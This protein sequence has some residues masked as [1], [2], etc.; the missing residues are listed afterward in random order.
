MRTQIVSLAIVLA[1]QGSF[2]CE[3]ALTDG[4]VD[5]AARLLIAAL[6]KRILSEAD[7]KELQADPK[8]LDSKMSPTASSVPFIVSLRRVIERMSD[9]DVDLLKKKISDHLQLL[10]KDHLAV[11]KAQRGTKRL[12]ISHPMLDFMDEEITLSRFKAAYRNGRPVFIRIDQSESTAFQIYDPFTPGNGKA[13]SYVSTHRVGDDAVNVFMH[14]GHVFA[15]NSDYSAI[16]N[17]SSGKLATLPLSPTIG[18]EEYFRGWVTY[19]DGVPTLIRVTSILEGIKKEVKATVAP[20]LREDQNIGIKRFN[21]GYPISYSLANQNAFLA[22][23]V[24]WGDSVENEGLIRFYDLLS[25]EKISEV[26]LVMNKSRIP[27]VKPHLF[28]L[29]ETWMA[30]LPVASGSG[31]TIAIIDIYAGK[32]VQVLG[33]LSFPRIH[34]LGTIKSEGKQVI[35]ASVSEDLDSDDRFLLLFDP[36]SSSLHRIPIESWNDIE[37][38]H[39]DERALLMWSNG[40]KGFTVFDVAS[41]QTVAHGPQAP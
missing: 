31:S 33:H 9:Q 36:L 32:T 35:Y 38:F 1:A 20:L 18:T 5:T 11:E 16:V 25:A 2:A 3:K 8:S 22:G 10:T 29:N 41:M 26:K 13:V 12:F 39:Y 34:Q 23:A 14:Q 37:A 40:K 24:Y 21:L 28:P 6:E 27:E 7:L 30:V 17:L 19:A 4:G 15:A